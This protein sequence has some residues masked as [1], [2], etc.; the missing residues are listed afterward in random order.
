MPNQRASKLMTVSLPPPLYEAAL[1]AARAQGRTNSEF[2]RESIRKYLADGKWKALLEYGRR[3]AIV[4]GL[5]PGDIEGIVD[6]IRSK[7]KR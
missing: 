5:R 3:K 1:K 6:G 4:A 7:K 2:V